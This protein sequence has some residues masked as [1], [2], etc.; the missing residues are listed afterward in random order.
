MPFF[1]YFI[2]Q[3]NENDIVCNM[4]TSKK[5]KYFLVIYI[6]FRN[7]CKTIIINLSFIGYF[8]VLVV[9]G[10]LE[11]EMITGSAE[12]ID[13]GTSAS[14]CDN[15]TSFPAPFYAGGGG[16]GL[17]NEPLVCQGKH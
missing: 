8:K 13:L 5:I 14:T 1:V 17:R 15:L 16:L 4:H 7:N 12:V 2:S 3:A 11:S 10:I 6:L 9:G